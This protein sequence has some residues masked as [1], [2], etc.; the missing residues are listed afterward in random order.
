MSTAEDLFYVTR[1]DGRSAERPRRVVFVGSLDEAKAKFSAI[2]PRTSIS[3]A[4]TVLWRGP[5]TCGYTFWRDGVAPLAA[6]LLH[7]DGEAEALEARDKRRARAA[8]RAGLRVDVA[9]ERRRVEVERARVDDVHGF[10]VAIDDQ[11]AEDE[12][13]AAERPELRAHKLGAHD[14]LGFDR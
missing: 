13:D 14:P 4:E 10:R 3:Y 5:P 6:E 12:D 8:K 9:P 2:I 1:H 11:A 7:V